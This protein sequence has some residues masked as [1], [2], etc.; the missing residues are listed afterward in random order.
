MH[1]AEE[2]GTAVAGVVVG[3]RLGWLQPT[4]FHDS[5]IRKLEEVASKETTDTKI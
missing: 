4:K 3:T 5:V 2:A 1:K